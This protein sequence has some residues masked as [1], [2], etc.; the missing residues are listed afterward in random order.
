MKTW[1]L[2]LGLS[3][4]LLAG[5]ASQQTLAESKAIP[6]GA[7]HIVLIRTGSMAG[8]IWKPSVYDPGRVYDGEKLCSEPERVRFPDGWLVGELGNGKRLTWN[9]L[10]GPMWLTLECGGFTSHRMIEEIVTEPGKEYTIEVGTFLRMRD[11]KPP[12]VTVRDLP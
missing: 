7:S 5:C 10:P 4:I 11:N 2:I 3:S 9:R 6:K 12:K 8:A 1:Y